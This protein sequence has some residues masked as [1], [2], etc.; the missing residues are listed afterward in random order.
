MEEEKKISVVIPVYNTE[1]YI[2]RCIYSILNQTYKDL[3]IICVDDGST[4]KSGDILDRLSKE[5]SRIRVKKKKNEGVSVARN[6]ALIEAKGDYIGFVDSDDYV[7][8]RYYEVLSEALNSGHI[9][10]VTCNYFI[11][12]VGNIVKVENKKKLNRDQY[13]LEN[14]CHTFMNA[15]HIKG[16]LHIYGQN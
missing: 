10:I 15:I 6:T 8:P 11:D 3:E 13:L 16:W 2:E 5:D 7:D 14:F 9:D 12:Y 4:D 1:K